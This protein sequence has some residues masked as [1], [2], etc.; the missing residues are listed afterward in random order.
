MSLSSVWTGEGLNDALFFLVGLVT[1]TLSTLQLLLTVRGFLSSAGV[2]TLLSLNGWPVFF[3][4][5][6]PPSPSLAFPLPLSFSPL[7][8]CVSTF[9]VVSIPSEAEEMGELYLEPTDG[10][11]LLFFRGEL[12]L[13]MVSNRAWCVAVKLDTDT[14]HK[15]S[16]VAELLHATS[17]SPSICLVNERNRSLTTGVRQL[18]AWSSWCCLRTSSRA[19]R[20]NLRGI[21]SEW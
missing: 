7:L 18:V 14:L 19:N 3:T 8:H 5:P 15:L 1:G 2:A 13:T 16:S 6:P 4:S 12:W 10:W 20:K 21:G 11:L 9:P 17:F